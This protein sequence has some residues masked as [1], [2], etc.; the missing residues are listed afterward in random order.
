[1]KFEKIR[2]ILG[3]KEKIVLEGVG[4]HKKKE[5]GERQDERISAKI[6]FRKVPMK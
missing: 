6:S 1:M 2:K 3:K 5:K 4:R